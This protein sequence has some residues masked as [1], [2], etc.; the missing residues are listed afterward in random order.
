MRESLEMKATTYKSKSQSG[1]LI[2]EKP[3]IR[4]CNER[5]FPSDP[6]SRHPGYIVKT[7]KPLSA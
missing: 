3:G 2:S 6:F 1:T 4:A 5:S 7:R